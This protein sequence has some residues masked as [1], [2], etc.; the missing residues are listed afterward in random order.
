MPLVFGKK[1]KDASACILMD[2][3]SRVLAKGRLEKPQSPNTLRVRITEGDV[4]AV[5]RTNK[6]QVVPAQ[7]DRTAALSR[8]IDCDD[9]DIITFE[10]LR[11]L[12][13]KE[14][15]TNLRMPVDFTSYAY[16]LS[17][18]SKVRAAI[19]ANDLSGGGISFYTTLSL[20]PGD[21]LEVVIP[22]TRTAPLLVQCQILRKGGTNGEYTLYAAK[23]PDLIDEQEALVREAVFRAQV[24][25]IREQRDA[26]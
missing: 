8:V 16:P 1:K 6:V 3:M 19:R 18:P 5:L 2:S 12:T 15:R 7:E 20:A 22:I 26:G 21:L 11:E 10:T 24:Q 4:K 14:V 23:F 13:G 17:G 9:H 25:H